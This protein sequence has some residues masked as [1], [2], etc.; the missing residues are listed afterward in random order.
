M[1]ERQD[2]TRRARLTATTLGLV[3]L[4]GQSSLAIAQPAASA[5]PRSA[6]T[7]SGSPSAQRPAPSTTSPHEETDEDGAEPQNPH[8][9]GAAGHGGG[10][11]GM[12]QPPEDGA[13]DDPSL[14]IGT[15]DI[16]IADPTGKPIPN[17]PVTLG[18]LYNS[19][20]KG[21]SRKRV[22][23][24]TNDQ[25]FARVEHL[26]TG[27][28][29]A[30]RPM[31]IT[32]GAT[33]SVMPFRLPEKTGMKAI[34]HVY[35]VVE[36]LDNTLIVTQSM[37]YTEVKDD[38][39]QVQ[40][41]F[42]IYNFGKTAWVPKDLVI[43][44]P[45]DF[46]AFSSQQGMT[47]VGVDAVPKK[48]IR[49]HGTF[50]PGQHVLEFRWQLPY[51]GESEVRFD[52]GMAPHMAA[53]RVIAPASKDM[54]LEVPGFPPPQATNDGQGQRALVTEKQLRRED[55]AVASLTIVIKNL[56][57][58]GSAKIFAT[59]FSAVGLV[60][61]LVLGTKKPPPRDR[62]NE[63]SRLLADLEDLERAHLAG[64]VGP[65]TYER[66]RREIVDAIARTF[67]TE[68]PVTTAP[69]RKRS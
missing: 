53:A 37:L 47:D 31:V 32:D 40:Q 9:G 27:S 12:F 46:T 16:H 33:F 13:V 28:V 45:E 29:V 17:T 52:V 58:E 63:R 65:K 69:K 10:N 23:V 49:V 34:L 64:D 54:V 38:R 67:A 36:E 21:E 35:P 3:A 30:Y 1:T 66:A 60:L 62:K 5:T 42:K 55:K 6:A 48:G 56:P 43:P 18:I 7:S 20:A 4:L 14:P 2:R 57:T 51:A 50:G 25:G 68:S 15:L 39:V 61:G 44:L 11:N 26:D 22:M 59:L 24:T 8:G 19:V 41:A